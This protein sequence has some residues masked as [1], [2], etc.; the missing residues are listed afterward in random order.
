MNIQLTDQ[1]LIEQI[2][3]ITV[4]RSRTPEQIV[5]EALKQYI[6]EQFAQDIP[7]KVF[8]AGETERMTLEELIE[9]TKSMLRHF[10]ENADTI[11]SELKPSRDAGLLGV[12]NRLAQRIDAAENERDLLTI[13]NVVHDLTIEIPYFPPDD[14]PPEHFRL[15]NQR[16][17]ADGR[18]K[19]HKATLKEVFDPCFEQI[20]QAWR[21][22]PSI[23]PERASKGSKE[24][25]WHL[26]GVFKD[27]PTW[28]E[29]FDEIERERDKDIWMGETV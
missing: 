29:I 14:E 28:G 26:M 19:T 20:E 17:S 12:M 11:M 15:E 5:T 21:N 6:R 18:I 9:R 3:H 7:D 8:C 27:D 13:A 22:L 23:I 25:P 24:T 1:T 10:T 2:S 4:Q 16:S